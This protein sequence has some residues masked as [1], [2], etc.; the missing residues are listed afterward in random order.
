M[1]ARAWILSCVFAL[2]LMTAGC[3]GSTATQ[4]GDTPAIAQGACEAA[5]A[6]APGAYI[7]NIVSGDAVI[8]DPTSNDFYLFCTPADARKHL[9]KRIQEKALPDGDWKIYRVHGT[10]DEL[11]TEISPGNFLLNVPAPLVDWV[12]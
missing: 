8:L 6:Y 7:I 11:V 10:W 2:S 4:G 3:F 12:D 5:Y 9:A 1:T